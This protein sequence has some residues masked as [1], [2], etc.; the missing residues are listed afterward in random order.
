[1][2]RGGA[3]GNPLESCRCTY[4]NDDSPGLRTP[5]LGFRVAKTLP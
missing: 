3:W 1:V 5:F 4:R 2:I